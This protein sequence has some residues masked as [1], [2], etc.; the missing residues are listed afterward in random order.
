MKH[1]G[2]MDKYSLE[3]WFHNPM[4]IHICVK[5]TGDLSIVEPGVTVGWQ[6]GR[7]ALNFKFCIFDF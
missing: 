7:Q 3:Q 2:A 4:R 1:H 6:A 5:K